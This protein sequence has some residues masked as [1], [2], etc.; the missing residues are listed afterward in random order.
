AARA[1]E[2]RRAAPASEGGE[3]P[4]AQSAVAG[5]EGVY[6]LD[7]SGG[8]SDGHERRQARQALSGSPGRRGAAGEFGV[9]GRYRLSL[10]ALEATAGPERVAEDQRRARAA[11]LSRHRGS[12]EGTDFERYRAAIENYDPSVKPGNQTSLNAARVPFASYINQ[13]HNQIHPI[14]ADSFLGSLDNLPKEHPLS[15]MKMFA[16]LEI[17]LTKEGRLTKMGIVRTSGNTA[18]DI[19][20][21]AA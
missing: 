19:A 15:N 4:R 16:R 1:Q 17:V 8:E 3:G 21:L 18:F 7:P 20:A 9:P 11:R 14:F 2:G 13:M 6:S 5:A 10:G 12:W